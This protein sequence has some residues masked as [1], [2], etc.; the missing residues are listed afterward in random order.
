MEC[1]KMAVSA[2]VNDGGCAFMCGI[3]WQYCLGSIGLACAYV[4]A[5]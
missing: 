1:A 5:L 4:A 2:C 3:V